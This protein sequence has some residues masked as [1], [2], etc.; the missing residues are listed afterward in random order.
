MGVCNELSYRESSAPKVSAQSGWSRSFGTPRSMKGL[1]DLQGYGKR[2]CS[3]PVLLAQQFL[4]LELDDDGLLQ[5]AAAT[6]GQE[7]ILHRWGF[8]ALILP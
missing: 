2:R 5:A 1:L 6:A 8:S 4:E 3:S 7:G